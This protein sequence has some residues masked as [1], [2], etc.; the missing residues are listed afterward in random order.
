[1][2]G[3]GLGQGSVL[4]NADGP[5]L[6]RTNVTGRWHVSWWNR[7]EQNQP[8]PWKLRR[9]R[10]RKS[11]QTTQSTEHLEPR[12]VLGSLTP[13]ATGTI[14]GSLLPVEMVDFLSPAERQDI[15][16]GDLALLEA[17][18]QH[19]L[20]REKLAW[21]DQLRSRKEAGVEAEADDESRADDARTAD[22]GEHQTQTTGDG[23][24]PAVNE[25]EA[26]ADE[27]SQDQLTDLK[28]E[29]PTEAEGNSEDDL[30]DENEDESETSELTED[31]T[32]EDPAERTTNDGSA[33]IADRTDGYSP[34]SASPQGNSVADG[35]APNAGVA[36]AG[37]EGTF[38][39]A[40][41]ASFFASNN[42][43]TPVYS[44]QTDD[45]LSSFD[46]NANVDPVQ[47][48]YDFRDLGQHANQI[49]VA[50]QASATAALQA[51]TTA[52]NGR[53]EFVRDTEAPASEIIVLGK[54][55]LAAFNYQSEQ[56]GTLAIGGGTPTLF[57][58]GSIGVTGIAW[59]DAAETWDTQIENGASEGDT[60]DA[61]T[62]FAHEIGHTLGADDAASH[63]TGD[64][65]NGIYDAERDVS[66]IEYAVR[67]HEFAALNPDFTPSGDG[68]Y[69]MHAMITGYPQLPAGEVE[70]IIDFATAISPSRDAIIA[71]VD[72]SGNILGVRTEDGVSANITGNPEVLAFAIDGAVAK[73]RTAAFFANGDP[74]NGTFAPITSRLVRFIS[75]S[76]VSYREVASNPNVLVPGSTVVS[77]VRTGTLPDGTPFA[78]GGVTADTNYY[79]PGLVAPI[80]L[81]GH[82]PPEIEHTPP[83]DLFHIEQ[84]NRDGSVH[85]GSDGIRGTGDDITLTNR[86]DIDPAFVPTDTDGDP[87]TI[88]NNVPGQLRIGTPDSW[89]FVSGVYPEAQARGIATLPGGVPLYRDTNGDGVGETLIGGIG[90]FF[91]GEN[92]TA[93]FEQG[94]A[95]GQT[96]AAR[97]NASRVLEA[98]FIAVVAAGGSNQLNALVAGT[99]PAG[100][101]VPDLDI[102]FGRLD[103][104]GIQLQ[105]IGPTAGLRGARQL[106]EFSH[107]LGD[108]GNI[109]NVNGTAQDVLPGID[110]RDGQTVPFGWLVTPH[111]GANISAAEVRQIIEQGIAQS[112][113]VRAAIR[114][115][116][117]SRTRMMYAV[118]DLDGEVLGLFRQRDATIFSIDVAVSKAR[119]VAYYA[120]ATVLD[121]LD[122]VTR[123]I[124][125]TPVPAGTAFTNRT[126]RFLAEPNFPSGVD[127]TMPGDFS[128]L[129]DLSSGVAALGQ[130][131]PA[132][133][134][135]NKT[136]LV[137][138][139]GPIPH[140]E[141][142]LANGTVAGLT[143]FFPATNM[144]DP[145]NPEHTNGV[146]FF[147]GSTAIYDPVTGDLIAGFGVS[148]DGVDQDDVVT[149]NGAAGFLPPDAVLRADEVFVEGVRLPYA[150]F[151]RNPRG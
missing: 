103:L 138:F 47:V 124:E 89:G 10:R 107:S 76:T 66:A 71:V 17:E 43:N 83:V 65:M 127:A 140:T 147:P 148:G 78:Y 91:P 87:L 53:L 151:L 20:V 112:E 11:S 93:E 6:I 32:D 41:I 34:G 121:P 126:I 26:D 52:T 21:L 2:R 131:V 143:S 106:V 40:D 116:L 102:P 23:E 146:I 14:V 97:T 100:H 130:S 49:T 79:G 101:P 99:K 44:P 109:A 141:F 108:V 51:W 36:A 122:Q 149:Y 90:V 67:H 13:T 42:S 70:G 64:I 45:S 133:G 104:V 19:E 82:F 39:A 95:P 35:A 123:T 86:F 18:H 110:Y 15:D 98:E 105:V 54:G 81:G 31:E 24:T 59:L 8:K 75:Q 88:D 117:G 129:H 56:G 125:G 120:D 96:E 37:G 119:N 16:V 62:V 29:T 50:E 22:E 134:K 68:T 1:M 144:R 80:G 69:E 74:I 135:V 114:L 150:K 139:Q 142:D 3:S 77:P 5:E 55:D 118:T 48:R 60:F 33:P 132:Q 63:R 136:S 84:T 12:V 72:R 57:E 128:I 137:E 94:F 111:D 73:A 7:S 85:P 46:A 27:V 28:A 4:S 58:D 38:A 30:T 145:D 115:P 9:A 61:F 25:T 92:G 113:S